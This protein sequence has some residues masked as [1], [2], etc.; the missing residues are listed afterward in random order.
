M[1]ATAEHGAKSRTPHSAVPTIIGWSCV[2]LAFVSLING[3]KALLYPRY[4]D[5]FWPDVVYSG[6]GLPPLLSGLMCVICALVARTA[7]FHRKMRFRQVVGKGTVL[8]RLDY[9]RVTG[10]RVYCLVI[11][12]VN[13]AGQQIQEHYY[14]N[15]HTYLLARKGDKLNVRSTE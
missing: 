10:E 3:I 8:K 6:F 15:Q 12:G 13:R 1:Q 5:Y 2:L 11:A 14:V 4:G 9:P 7:F